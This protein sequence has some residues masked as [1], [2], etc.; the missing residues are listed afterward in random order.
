MARKTT[1]EIVIKGTDDGAVSTMKKVD[2]AAKGMGVSV[3]QSGD[4]A[5]AAQKGFAKFTAF[6]KDRFVVTLGDV[7][8]AVSAA[9]GAIKDSADLRS[10]TNALKLALA[11]QGK[12]FNKYIAKLKEVSRGTVATADLI[13]SSS[14]ALLLG[15]PAEEISKLLE[16]ARASAIATGQSV[17]KA[18][19]DIT[20]GIGRTSPLILDNLGLVVR[21]GDANKKYAESVGK[22][23]TELTAEERKT[24]L[25]NEVL[26][27]GEERITTFGEAADKTSQAIAKATAAL[28]NMKD[29]AGNLATGALQLLAINI[30]FLDVA[31]QQAIITFQKMR[32]A[33]NEFVGD[34]DDVRKISALIGELDKVMTATLTRGIDLAN[35]VKASFSAAFGVVGGSVDS[36]LG[37]TKAVGDAKD[38]VDELGDAAGDAEPKVGELK[39]KFDETADVL[40]DDLL[41]ALTL[42]D[43]S[44]ESTTRRADAAAVS[45]DVLSASQGRA[46]AVTAQ[47]AANIA[48]G[49]PTGGLSLRGTRIDV[50]GGSRLTSSPG[51]SNIYDGNQRRPGDDAFSRRFLNF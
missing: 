27:L 4:D 33:F 43:K 6:L 10:Q 29:S 5:V 44:L 18:F 49:D 7:S 48:A 24:A 16:I 34:A 22:L 1:A 21:I 42:L 51:F 50:P 47:L 17:T 15:I 39:E 35:G 12:D 40:D 13:K 11:T 37:M 41:P 28:Q 9:F 14:R 45:F 36:I 31:V 26:A 25:L 30:V 3:K 8:R 23:V 38:A 19:N 20:T 2:G 46:A 32:L